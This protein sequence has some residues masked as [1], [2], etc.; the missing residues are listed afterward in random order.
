M[1]RD[2]PQLPLS[3]HP[4]LRLLNTT[5]ID[6]QSYAITM[7]FPRKHR[8][9]FKLGAAFAAIFTT[10]CVDVE[11]P[12]ASWGNIAPATRSHDC[13]SVAATYSNKGTNTAG[14]EVHLASSLHPRNSPTRGIEGDIA[15]AQTVTLELDG[16]L[17]TVT[18][19]GSNGAYHQWSFDK[20][21]QEF[22][23][24]DGVLRIS[25]DGDVGGQNV[26]L[27]GADTIDLYRT[28]SELFVNH[29]GRSTGL[30]LMIPVA[31]RFSG[32]E[33]FHVA[34]STL[35]PTSLPSDQ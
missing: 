5:M 12:P 14:V 33:R 13:V 4:L 17:L 3:G 23:C 10:A 35:S 2:P 7:C 16:S 26:A 32:W 27:V 25:Q 29:Q 22:G 6:P 1:G 11:Y 18:I 15:E 31:E 28:Q 30:A 21:K 24:R 20:S 34:A 19:N 9:I 8:R